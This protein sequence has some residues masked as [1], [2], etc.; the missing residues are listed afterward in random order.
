MLTKKVAVDM[1]NAIPFGDDRTAD[2]VGA[3]CLRIVTQYKHLGS[4][5][6]HD[7]SPNA[8]VSKR[9]SSALAA[10]S[11]LAARV[12]GA[13]HVSRALKLQLCDSLVMSRLLYN[14]Q[15]WSVVS[16][17]ALRKMNSVY[18]RV[19]R[20]IANATWSPR[21]PLLSDVAVRRL[22]SVPSIDALILQRRLQHL[23]AI[24]QADI[25][26]LSS[27]LAVT[28]RGDD[29]TRMPWVR[30]V[31][32]DLS[33]LAQYH[34]DKL[35]ELGDPCNHAC[36]W[37]SFIAS[38]PHEWKTLV[39]QY[40]SFVSVCDRNHEHAATTANLHSEHICTECLHEGSRI[41]FASGKALQCHRRVKHGVRSCLKSFV[42]DSHT[43]PVCHTKFSSR[44]RVIA[45]LSEKRKRGRAS[46]T[47]GSKL[48]TSNC[49]RLPDSVVSS[50]NARD[51][52]EVRAAKR[53]GRVQPQ[54]SFSAK[55]SRVRAVPDSE[56]FCFCMPKYRLRQK[57]RI[58]VCHDPSCA[59]PKRRRSHIAQCA[60]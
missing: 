9:V 6:C 10:F 48:L 43:C 39:S 26:A 28:S 55:R 16:L 24:V 11:P 27:M 22:L 35:S 40:K 44:L 7:G 31:I 60:P 54:V 19:L 3:K 21:K 45:H 12:F 15:T 32:E 29:S 46:T 14:V 8:D 33:K 20:R 59:P 58:C 1:G 18:M 30:T 38:Y 56:C 36:L 47:C 42:D 5:I 37:V 23:A 4:Y 50:L 13:R 51:A 25:S 52:S 17:W 53:K 49:E 41:T 2:E 34:H 57:T